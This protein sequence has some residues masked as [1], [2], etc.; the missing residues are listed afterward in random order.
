[1]ATRPAA[2]AESPTHG[3]RESLVQDAKSAPYGEGFKITLTCPQC[4]TTA[5]V[6]WKRL[7]HSLRCPK[8]RCQFLIGPHGKL[9]KPEDLPQTRYSCPRCGAAGSVPTMLTVR[10]AECMSCKLPL[11]HGPDQRLHGVKE[12]A[13]L[14][15]QTLET[16]REMRGSKTPTWLLAISTGLERRLGKLSLAVVAIVAAGAI[17]Y[18]GCAI[19]NFFTP[20]PDRQVIGFV[21]CCLEGDTDA[22]EKYLADDDV[23]RAEFD[24]WRV[25]NFASIIEK[26]RPAGDDPEITASLLSETPDA[27]S[28]EITMKSPFLGERKLRQEWRLWNGDWRFSPVETLAQQDG[29]R[30]TTIA[31]S[32]PAK[33]LTPRDLQAPAN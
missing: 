18:V 29:R 22:A 8:C 27:R 19:A 2:T 24:R 21:E 33:K 17:W 16:L 25:R 32:A 1:M 10:R 14:Q 13:E 23:E 6:A 30:S 3:D 7:T 28:Y 5:W 15:R 20:R 9:F 4:S 26:F 12:A 31:P 11:A